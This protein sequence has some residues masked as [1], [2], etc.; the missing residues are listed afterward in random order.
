MT[1]HAPSAPQPPSS[2]IGRKR[3]G[4]AWVAVAVGVPAA[5]VVAFVLL[6]GGVT[7]HGE[8]KIASLAAHPDP[9]LHGTV[10]YLGTDWCV[11]VAAAS[12]RSSRQ[13]LCIG[14]AE[15]LEPRGKTKLVG[16]QLVWR[17][18]GRLEV[19]MFRM[20]VGKGEPPRYSA[21]WQKIVDVRTGAVEQTPAAD[22]PSSWNMS[23]RTTTNPR[24]E[25]LS[26]YNSPSGTG[27]IEITLTGANG[28]RRNLLTAQGPGSYT[29]HLY[30]AFWSPDWQ[31]IA[32]DDGRILITTPGTPAITRVLTDQ[33]ASGGFN[34][35]PAIANF[36]V[37]SADLLDR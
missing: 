30:S 23:T 24:G 10:A 29:Y 35:D 11:R 3:H 27:R 25:K 26:I 19:T 1:V 17:A 13:V 22:L 36:A 33:A 18:D 16:P 4:K 28:V 15:R 5:L 32:A 31:W 8:P 6:I 21:G 7:G 20:S 9:S 34:D 12:G 37:T 14:P 2:A